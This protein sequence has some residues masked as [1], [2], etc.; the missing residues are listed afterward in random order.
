MR[1]H[2]PAIAVATIGAGGLL[3]ACTVTTTTNNNGPAGDDASVVTPT[4]D[5]SAPTPDGG[6]V[7]SVGDD[8]GV[9]SGDAATAAPQAYIRIAHWSPDAPA[10]DVCVNTAGA[11]WTGQ[12][13]Q[14]A[15]LVAAGDAGTLGDGG[16]VGVSFPQVTSYLII[17]PGSYAVRLVA[18]GSADCSTALVDLANVTLAAR[19][20]T[21]IAALGEAT[22]VGTD[23]PL[24]LAPFTDDVTAP[25]G[26]IALRFINASP[27]PTLAPADLGTGSLAGSGGP[28]APLFTGVA[29]GQTGATSGSDAGTVDANGYVAIGPLA[30]ATL[31]AH[32]TATA[33][34]A[35]VAL[36]DVTIAATSAATVALVNG[37]SNGLA[38]SAVKL[39]QCSDV[40]D[41]TG[42]S[43]LSTCSV[44]STQ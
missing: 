9:D 4:D 35:T 38:S 22:P 3:F 34:D 42:S 2:F 24:S 26:Q 13:P 29:F 10:A 31:S 7:V 43:L 1:T 17:P 36:N 25:A 16:A 12:T 6:T 14:L 27:A 30:T 21:T 37:V 15:Q 28:F 8:A 44:V 11:D 23:Q 40:D 5:S 20:Y 18:A 41:S 32:P 33:S 39:L 19:S